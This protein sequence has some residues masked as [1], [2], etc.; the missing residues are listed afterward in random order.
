MLGD[1]ES[2]ST[3]RAHEAVLREEQE[4][5]GM[6]IAE[7]VRTHLRER[8]WRS[9]IGGMLVLLRYHPRELAL[10]D[11]RRMERYRLARRFRDRTLEL[12]AREQQLKRQART[13]EKERQEV[14]QELRARERQLKRQARAL[15]KERQE[16]RRLRLQVQSLGRQLRELQGPGIWGLVQRLKKRSDRGLEGKAAL[17]AEIPAAKLRP[18][19]PGAEQAAGAESV[20]SLRS[21]GTLLGMEHKTRFFLVGEMKSG[22]SWLM[23]MLNSH[24]EIFCGAEGTFFGRHRAADEI[25]VYEARAPS[26]YNALLNSEDLR[27]WQSLWWNNWTKR[28]KT[29]EEDLHN[30]T[31]LAIDYYLAKGSAASGKR[32]VGDKSPQHTDYVDEIFDFYPEAKVIHIFRDGRDVAVSLMHHFWNMSRDKRRMSKGGLF[33]LEPEELAKRDAYL[34]D[35]EAFLASG[36]S[37]F[38]EE[39]LR[40]MAARWS[41]MV[42]KASHDGSKLF[43]PNFFELSYEDLLERPEENLKAVFEFLGARADDDIIRWCVEENS[44]EE[45]AGRSRGHE[46]GSSFFRKGVAGDWRRVFTDRNRR[47]YENIAKDTLLEM[48]YPL[49]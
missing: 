28:G 14:R 19:L 15:E 24:S 39:R 42:S 7:K 12:E 37:I 32:I 48:G 20:G 9:A 6:P 40:Q 23:N 29:A 11:G 8:E 17:P 10:L 31:R 3:Q 27:T 5:Y 47:V 49:D 46:D 35:P 45:W 33:D 30:L 25:P 1:R 4:R 2:E 26:L 34:A 13:L 38:L 36:D 41:R 44:F 18:E 22:T 16:V 43:G 21:G